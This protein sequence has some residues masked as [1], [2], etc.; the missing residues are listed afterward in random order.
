[1]RKY[2]SKFTAY[3]SISLRV[4]IIKKKRKEKKMSKV[5]TESNLK[6]LLYEAVHLNSP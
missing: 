1:M 2:T 5:I 4:A 6:A 3:F